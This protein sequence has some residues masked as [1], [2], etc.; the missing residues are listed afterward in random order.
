MSIE[1]N[2][3][4]DE[5]ELEERLE[6]TKALFVEDPKHFVNYGE[7][8]FRESRDTNINIRRKWKETWDAY[9]L[10]QNYDEKEDWQSK[11]TT[12]K[13]FSTVQQATAIVQK[14][15][16]TSKDFFSIEPIDVEND[17]IELVRKG[18]ID[19]KIIQN[20]LKIVQ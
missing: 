14:A 8:C 19:F 12:A 15:L 9:L 5:Q 3:D 20:S 10:R 17:E 6:A 18:A 1:K 13:P 11:I 4:L 2:I 16:G 7:A